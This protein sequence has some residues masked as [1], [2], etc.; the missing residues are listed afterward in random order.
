MR[1][2]N[3]VQRMMFGLKV[4]RGGWRKLHKKSFTIFTYH[5]TLLT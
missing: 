5:L 4:V 1:L 2:E 3:K